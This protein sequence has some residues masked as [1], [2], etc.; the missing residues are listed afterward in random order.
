MI[1]LKNKPTGCE[2]CPFCYES[3][4][5]ERV[6]GKISPSHSRRCGALMGEANF[7]NCPLVD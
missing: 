6:N 3:E 1:K 2:N 4:R 7:Q 5:Y